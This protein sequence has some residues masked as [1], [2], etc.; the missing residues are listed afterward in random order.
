MEK[1]YILVGDNYATFAKHNDVLTV[2]QLREELENSLDWKGDEKVIFGLGIDDNTRTLL[3]AALNARGIE[4]IMSETNLAPTHLTHKKYRENSLITT[5]KSIQAMQYEF[6]LCLDD[7]MDRLAD[8]VTGQHLSA[9]LLM[10]AS[11]QAAIASLELEY[12]SRNDAKFGIVMEKIACRF[13]NFAFPI[14]TLI[15]VNI[16]ELGVSANQNISVECIIKFLQADKVVCEIDMAG[17]ITKLHQLE[18]VETSMAR[19]SIKALRKKY[20]PQVESNAEC[21]V[22]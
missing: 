20:K 6:Y 10:E 2:S 22:A 4:E 3:K 5:P 17:S 1:I 15:T 14:P 8:H 11:R 16:N 12:R 21:L 19:R 13:N 9:M 18:P 7:R